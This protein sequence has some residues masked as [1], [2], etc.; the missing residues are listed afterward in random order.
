MFHKLT[1]NS[2]IG[3]SRA[4]KDSVMEGPPI[5]FIINK[6]SPPSDDE[7]SNKLLKQWKGSGNIS[8]RNSIIPTTAKE[9]YVVLGP[10]QIQPKG[11]RLTSGRYGELKLGFYKIKGTVEVE[12]SY[13]KFFS[14]IFFYL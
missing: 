10:G 5:G 9:P 1:T 6:S 7:D 8:A 4:R 13:H 2:I 14:L 11:Y 12:V 3:S